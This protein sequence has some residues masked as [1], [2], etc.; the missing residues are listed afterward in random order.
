MCVRKQV[1]S[2]VIIFTDTRGFQFGVCHGYDSV[3]QV[4][5]G[6]VCFLA[7]PYCKFDGVDPSILQR[8]HFAEVPGYTVRFV[9]GRTGSTFVSF[10]RGALD[11]FRLFAVQRL[12]VIL[13]A[14]CF[15]SSN[16]RAHVRERRN[17]VVHG[18]VCSGHTGDDLSGNLTER[19]MHGSCICAIN[20]TC[21]VGFRYHISKV[22]KPIRR[23]T[24]DTVK[25]S[26]SGKT[27]RGSLR[28]W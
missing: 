28:I 12:N 14:A 1:I 5:N 13:K 22:I 16:V 23:A 4:R 15:A 8:A 3:V 7:G 20:C 26:F 21:A 9:V 6:I 17:T 11:P 2:T 10:T 25:N 24:E 19:I 27:V 18:D